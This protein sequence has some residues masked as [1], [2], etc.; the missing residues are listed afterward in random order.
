LIIQRLLD[1]VSYR[2][3]SQPHIVLDRERCRTCSVRACTFVCPA[4]CYEWNA[5][6]QQVDFAYEACLECGT[7][8]LVCD[9][10]ALDWRYPDGGFGVRFRM[11]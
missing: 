3:H 5:E 1:L 4:G 9:K 11:T 10:K 7:C 8:L 2:V 6:R